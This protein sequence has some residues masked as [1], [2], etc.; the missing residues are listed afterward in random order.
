MADQ[1]VSRLV[2]EFIMAGDLLMITGHEIFSALAVHRNK[3]FSGCSVY[4]H[5]PLGLEPPTTLCGR[6]GLY[7]CTKGCGD[8][9]GPT[10]A[11]ELAYVRLD[12]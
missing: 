4:P 11:E 12:S 6:R 9:S 1:S 8:S 7:W 3:G 10:R 2:N 5:P